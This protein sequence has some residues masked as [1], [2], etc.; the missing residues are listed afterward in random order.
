MN[1]EAEKN[2][3]NNPKVIE[4]LEQDVMQIVRG[5]LNYILSFCDREQPL[6]KEH[7]AQ[8]KDSV[9]EYIILVQSKFIEAKESFK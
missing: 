7:E 6:S 8:L 5:R 9:R 3:M 1:F 4:K 2:N